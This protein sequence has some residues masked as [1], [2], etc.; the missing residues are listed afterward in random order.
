MAI[1]QRSRLQTFTV[2]N[3]SG[4]PLFSRANRPRRVTLSL[5]VTNSP[6]P[7]RKPEASASPTRLTQAPCEGRSI[8]NSQVARKMPHLSIQGRTDN[9]FL[10]NSRAGR[11]RIRTNEPPTKVLNEL[12]PSAFAPPSGVLADARYTVSQCTRNVLEC[13]CCT[14][15]PVFTRKGIRLTSLVEHRD[16]KGTLLDTEILSPYG[17]GS[18]IRNVQ[19]SHPESSS[20]CS[21]SSPVQEVAIDTDLQVLH[22]PPDV[23]DDSEMDLTKRSDLGSQINDVKEKLEK[24]FPPSLVRKST[25]ILTQLALLAVGLNSDTNLTSVV[26]RCISFLDA[27]L[28][29]G[30]VMSLHDLLNDYV[31][32]AVMP[33]V[34][35]GRKFEDAFALEHASQ[36]EALSEHTIAIWDTLKKGIFTK[37]V[38]YL[39]G[40]AF[41]FFT[42]KIQNV[43]FS[44]PLQTKIIEHAT[45]DKIDAVDLIDHVVKLYN[46]ASTVGIACFQQKSLKPLYLNSGSLAKCHSKYY[47]IRQWYIDA[48]RDGNTTAE[49]RQSKFI[50][51]ETVYKT[52]TD[53]CKVDRDKFTTL[54]ASTLIHSVG[55]L[56]NDIKDLV[57]KVDAV[58][59]ARAIHLWGQPKV[60]KSFITN[61]VHEQHCVA[62]GQKYRAADNAQLNLQAKFFDE[63]TNSTQCITI[64]E[65][66]PLKEAFAK[67]MEEA[68]TVALALVDPVPYHPN[69]SKLEEKAR[70]TC[71]HVSVIS[72]GNTEEPFIHVAKTPGAWCRRYTSVYMRVKPEYADAD[73]RFDSRKRDGTNRYHLFDVYEIIYDEERNKRRKYF[74]FED[75]DS[76]DMETDKFMELIRHLAIEHYANEDNLEELRK[77]KKQDGCLKCKRLAHF[78]K[79]KSGELDMDFDNLTKVQASVISGVDKEFRCAYSE[80]LGPHGNVCDHGSD[81]QQ[82]CRRCGKKVPSQPESGVVNMAMSTAASIA[83]E[84]V[85]PYINPFC[86]LK[87]FWTI[88][89]ATHGYLREAIVEEVSRMPEGILTKSLSMI[90]QSW[91]ERNGKPTV[92]GDWKDRYIRYVAAENQIYLPITT[93]LKRSFTWSCLIFIFLTLLMFSIEGVGVWLKTH[94]MFLKHMYLFRPRDWEF[95]AIRAKETVRFG[96]IPLFPQWSKHVFENRDLYAA[97]GIYTMNYLDF[98]SYYVD[99]Y[100]IQRFLGRLHYYWFFKEITYV[101]VL[102]RKLFTWWVFPLTMACAYF[103]LFFLHMWIRR[104]AGLSRRIAQLQERT[105]SDPELRHRLLEKSKRHVSEFS[106]IPNAM[107]VMGAVLCAVSIWNIMRQSKPE[108]GL[109]REG[110][111]VQDWNSFFSFNRNVP[112]SSVDSSIS[113]DS[114]EQIISKHLCRV[115]AHVGGEKAF[116][117]GVW[118]RTG[119]LLLP[120]HFFKPNVMEDKVQDVTDLYIETGKGFNTKVR[121]YAASLR[122]M[123]GKDAVI[124][125]VPRSPKMRHD[126]V[127]YLPENQP[128]DCHSARILH[129]VEDADTY[130]VEVENINAKYISNVDC[131]GVKCGR[132]VTYPS[133]KTTF[134]SC[135]SPVIRKGVILGFHISGDYGVTQKYGNAQEITQQDYNK[136]LTMLKQDPD[137]ISMPEKGEIPRERLGYTLIEEYG[138][139]HPATKGFDD[140]DKHHGIEIIGNNT[141]LPRYRSRVRRSLISQYLEDELNK[142]CKWKA[143][144]MKRPWET[145]NKALKVLANGAWE[146]PPDAL[147]WAVDDYLE[148]LLKKIPTYKEKYPHLCKVLSLEQMVNGIP[149]SMYMKIVNMKSAIGPIGSGAGA[150]MYSDLFDEMD[151]LPSG[152]KQYRLSEKALA[153]FQEMKKCFRSGKKYGVWTKTCLKDEVVDEDSEKVRIFYILECLFA[154]IVRQ[155]YLPIIEFI[156]RHPHLTECAVGI[157][158]AGPEWEMTMQYVQE[159]AKDKLMVDWDYSKYDL[160]RSLDVM[161]ASL[162]VMRRIAQAFGYTTDD[163][164]VMDAIADELRN[165][166]INWNGTIMSCF[167]WSSGNSVTVYGNS[168]ENSLHNRISFYVNGVDLL[169]LE[170][171]EE[172]GP[173]RDNE[174]II[175]YGDDGQAGSRPEVREITKFSRREAYFSKIGMKITDAAKSNDPAEMVDRDLIDFLKRKSVYHPRLGVRVGALHAESIEKMLH[176]SSG[177][178]EDD[179]LAVCSI[180]TALLEFFLHEEEVYEQWRA[181]LKQAAHAHNIYTEYLDNHTK[182]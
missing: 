76:K 176:M 59:V 130:R 156:S 22:N 66:C 122:K 65:T 38:S 42:C 10:N 19:L 5:I 89:S 117:C 104:V 39:V 133:T 71:Q 1:V 43:E 58:K 132:G 162:N 166:I 35:K 61:D 79:C 44:H 168:I 165:P 99:L 163:L 125:K 55:N 134:G 131:G 150:K 36:P 96:A 95:V 63:L 73:G 30:V 69:R 74:R 70:I 128:T 101:Q 98:Q 112:K 93:L 13:T 16:N 158:C 174:R 159:L 80:E 7:Q 48:M 102:E 92:L 81:G 27:C 26:T 148:P 177:K 118:I 8:A 135:G 77:A 82:D 129:F 140:I 157:N 115:T 137:Y 167:L 160:R 2:L 142:P 33:D 49:I 54:S 145:H 155:Y 45:S 106:T 119:Q 9:K 120:R 109:E 37:H 40:T 141:N 41:A 78:C 151:P 178:G 94:R 31:S 181:D 149:E 23:D 6:N 153:H 107:G 24:D 67:S 57:L 123:E 175:T 72:T 127:S 53:L 100:E 52:L 91:L 64:N 47:E 182:N 110:N 68:F 11:I 21:Q 103:V 173:Y 14:V 86:K 83:R 4:T 15:I 46:W 29:D 75:G 3:T 34:L 12:S 170:K 97:R 32:S 17:D 56:Y 169:G 20:R 51:I 18:S 88:D 111:S 28:D 172:L 113:L 50:E 25:K 152:A 84:A 114:T 121:I 87:W 180:I 116:V 85:A 139:P 62:R 90:P 124:V 143:P 161:I 108:T 154:L 60:G 147:K 138:K 171:F 164:I 146:V 144:N 126:L 105:R 136:Y 179:E